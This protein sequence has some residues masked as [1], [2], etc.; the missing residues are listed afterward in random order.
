MHDGDN[1][2]MINESYISMIS[3]EIKNNVP[4]TRM[5]TAMDLRITISFLAFGVIF[6][7]ILAAIRWFLRGVSPLPCCV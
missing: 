3:T 7:R 1:W 6:G 2:K 4:T 5:V